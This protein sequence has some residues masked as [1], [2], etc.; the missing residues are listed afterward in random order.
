M[1]HTTRLRALLLAAP[2]ALLISMM[3]ETAISDEGM[4][5]FNQPPRKQLKEKYGFDPSN[6]WLE[7]LQKSAVRFN[8]GGAGAFFSAP[9]LVVRKPTIG[10]ACLQK[11]QSS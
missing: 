11:R 3:S 1:R 8:S 10:A 7:H 4:W 9:W 5:L 6:A 2:A